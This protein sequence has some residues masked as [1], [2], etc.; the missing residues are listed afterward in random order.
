MEND[1]ISFIFSLFQRSLKFSSFFFF[2]ITKCRSII[3]F[4]RKAKGATGRAEIAW[5][6]FDVCMDKK[7]TWKYCNFFRNHNFLLSIFLSSPFFRLASQWI[8]LSLFHLNFS[9]LS[10]IGF[11]LL[12]LYPKA[13]WVITEQ[14]VLFN[15]HAKHKRNE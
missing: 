2:L 12:L 14:Y 10:Q 8:E 15:M 3:W 5:V 11:C 4:A 13:F 9:S 1:A 7:N 6:Y